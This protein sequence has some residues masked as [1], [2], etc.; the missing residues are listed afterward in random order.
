MTTAKLLTTSVTVVLALGVFAPASAA[1]TDNRS[2]PVIFVH[3]LNR[4]DNAGSDCAKDFGV[5]RR[6]FRRWGHTGR[7]TA[8]SYYRFD[9]NCNHSISHHGKHR[10]HFGGDAEHYDAGGH[11]ANTDIRHLGYHLARYIW[12]HHSRHGRAVDIVG[13]SMGGLIARYAVAQTQRSHPDFPPRLLVEDIVT[14][15]TPHGGARWYS[16]GCRYD[17]CG[18]MR[19]GSGFLV[20]LEQNAWNPQGAGGTDWSTF[21]SDDDNAVAADRAAATARDRD[22]VS[23]YMGSCHKVWYRESTNIEHSEFLTSASKRI[24]ADVYRRNCPG[25][26]VTDNTSHWPVRRADLAITFGSH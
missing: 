24:T 9:R 8:V 15:G 19:A 7:F 16:I 12:R 2:K 4:S 14:L 13:H 10:R 18:Q 5:M 22:P 1:R 21:G 25:R 17:Q 20:W 11:S 3:G 26:F 23:D 6:A